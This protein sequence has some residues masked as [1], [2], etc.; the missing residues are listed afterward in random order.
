MPC[1]SLEAK[2]ARLKKIIS[3]AGPDLSGGALRV[4]HADPLQLLVAT[5][6]SAQCT[7]KRVNMVTAELFKK[8][9][10][11][12]DFAKR[13]RRTGAGRQVHRLFP[14]QGEKH[15]G[16]LPK[17]VERYGGKVPRTMEE[18]HRLT[19]SGARPPMSFWATRSASTSAW[20][21]TRTS[22][23]CRNRLGLTKQK[24]PEKIEPELMRSCRKSS[25]RCSVTG[26]SGTDAAAAV[27]ASRIA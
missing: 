15:P 2:T 1:E 27:R 23:G 4:E 3:R 6:L 8:Y 25:G 26:S 19:A 11:A 13:R 12:K 9:R 16:V 20:S 10:T 14:Q 22:R 7:D 24:T 18:L 5:I 17:L 21:W